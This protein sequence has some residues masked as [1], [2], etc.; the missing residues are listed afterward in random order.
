MADLYVILYDAI[1]TNP[2]TGHG[3][4]GFYFGENG[5]HR[6]YDIGKAV[7]EALVAIGKGKSPEPTTFTKEEIDKYFGVRG[8]G[9]A[10]GGTRCSLILGIGLPRLELT[11]SG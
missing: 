10:L 3:R 2:A 5:E 9:R 6:L 11:L 8:T 7:A 1:K 4:E